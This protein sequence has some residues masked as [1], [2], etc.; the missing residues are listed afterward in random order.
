MKIKSYLYA[1]VV[2]GLSLWRGCE[3]VHAVSKLKASMKPQEIQK[4]YLMLKEKLENAHNLKEKVLLTQNLLKFEKYYISPEDY[5]LEYSIQR[6]NGEIKSFSIQATTDENKRFS[7]ETPCEVK[8]TLNGEALYVQSKLDFDKKRDLS[9][10]V[11]VVVGREEFIFFVPYKN[12]TELTQEHKSAKGP[13]TSSVKL[14]IKKGLF[15]L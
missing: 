2:I 11:S 14:K 7:K 8:D 6:S 4:I 13:L 5:T 3:D 15:G 1:A 9:I 12:N 10:K